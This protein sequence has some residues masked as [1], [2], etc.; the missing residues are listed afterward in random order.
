MRSFLRF[1]V[2]IPRVAGGRIE[3]IYD[4]SMFIY[5]HRFFA[6]YSCVDYFRKEGAK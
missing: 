1:R 2:F 4:A 6:H 3:E 5:L